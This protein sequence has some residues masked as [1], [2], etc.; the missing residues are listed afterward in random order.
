[1][2]VGEGWEELVVGARVGGG[3]ARLWG[4]MAAGGPAELWLAFGSWW[5]VGGAVAG[6]WRGADDGGHLAEGRWRMPN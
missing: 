3:A 1:V 5:R 2:G 4:R 6:G